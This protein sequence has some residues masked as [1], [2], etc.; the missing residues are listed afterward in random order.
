MIPSSTI[1]TF[2]WLGCIQELLQVSSRLI[3][4]QCCVHTPLL[5]SHS[6]CLDIG[7]PKHSQQGQFQI[8]RLGYWRW[9]CVCTF[10]SSRLDNLFL[11]MSQQSP[12]LSTIHHFTPKKLTMGTFYRVTLVKTGLVLTGWQKPV[13]TT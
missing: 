7:G 13:K 2:L 9:C 6:I 1:G 10:L 4:S 5:L 3:D 12:L 8:C 11:C